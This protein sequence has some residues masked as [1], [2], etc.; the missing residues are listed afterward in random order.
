MGRA[1]RDKLVAANGCTPLTPEPMPNGNKA[2]VTDYKGCK[3]GYPMRWA[4][5]TGDHTPAYKDAGATDPM[6]GPNFWEFLSQFE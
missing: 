6:A 1:I 4:V 2:T 5:F 3:E